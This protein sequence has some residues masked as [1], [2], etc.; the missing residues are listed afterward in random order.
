MLYLNPK[1]ISSSQENMKKILS[2]DQNMVSANK[3]NYTLI[4]HSL[5]LY[6][7]TKSWYTSL[8][9]KLAANTP[10]YKSYILH[11]TIQYCTNFSSNFFPPILSIHIPPQQHIKAYRDRK[12]EH[13]RVTDKKI[14]HLHL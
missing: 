5:E 10:L 1:D 6:K 13:I 8:I 7:Y 11:D 4:Q 9:L 3:I 12:Q 14:Y 2:S